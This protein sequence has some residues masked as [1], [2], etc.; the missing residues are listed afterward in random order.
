[1]TFSHP[2]SAVQTS[3]KG[4]HDYVLGK[5]TLPSEYAYIRP[6]RSI[7]LRITVKNQGSDDNNPDQVPV[8]AWLGDYQLIPVNSGFHQMKGGTSAMYTL[9]YMIPMDIP[10]NSYHLTIKIDPWNTKGEDGP[11]QN[12]NTTPALVVIEDKSANDDIR[13]QS[14][15]SL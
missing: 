1:M 15:R 9:R 8:E 6:G 7:N 10:V 4:T 3:V 13:S 2:V 12:E 14:M 11:G 5:I